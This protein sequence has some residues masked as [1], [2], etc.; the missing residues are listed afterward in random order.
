MKVFCVRRYRECILVY[1]KIKLGPLFMQYGLDSILRNC[2][3]FFTQ[4]VNVVG[5]IIDYYVECWRIWNH[6]FCV[7]PVFCRAFRSIH[8]ADVSEPHTKDLSP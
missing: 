1:G 5:Y 6:L 3:V 7:K 8:Y 2:D 4:R